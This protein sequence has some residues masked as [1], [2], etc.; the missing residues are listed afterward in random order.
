[1]EDGGW[2]TEWKEEPRR[3]LL[4][5][6]PRGARFLPRQLVSPPRSALHPKNNSFLSLKRVLRLCESD[7]LYLSFSVESKMRHY[8]GV[9]YPENATERT[10]FKVVQ[11]ENR[12]RGG[13]RTRG[14]GRG[15]AQRERE[16]ERRRERRKLMAHELNAGGGGGE[17][18]FGTGAYD[19][20]MPSHSFM[21][22][23]SRNLLL[24]SICFFEDEDPLRPPHDKGV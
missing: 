12:N 13:R 9:G 16:R 5:C 18:R 8:W 21:L 1:M 20:R 7:P 3:Q 10:R 19:V 14:R 22:Y 11:R 24:L 2:K 15:R 17:R 23:R 4:S 6:F